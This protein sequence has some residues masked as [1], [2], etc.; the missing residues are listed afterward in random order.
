MDGPWVFAVSSGDSLTYSFATVT[1][2][3]GW[4]D[5]T[6]VADIEP[7]FLRRFAGHIETGFAQVGGMRPGFPF[8]SIE[9]QSGMVLLSYPAWASAYS[10]EETD[11]PFSGNWFTLNAPTVL[12]GSSILVTVPITSDTAYFRLRR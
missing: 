2:N 5:V 10:V 1:T 12:S 4:Y 9:L 3:H 6:A 7:G 11:D 8:L